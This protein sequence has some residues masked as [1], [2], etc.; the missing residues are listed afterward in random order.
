MTTPSARQFVHRLALRRRVQ[1]PDGSYQENDYATDVP[2]T[3]APLPPQTSTDSDA[4]VDVGGFTCT[5]HAA[6]LRESNKARIGDRATLV[7]VDGSTH[8]LE[9]K[10]TGFRLDNRRTYLD[11][12]L[13][14]VEE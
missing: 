9:V 11:L 8:Q 13:H 14:F 10:R 1:Q 6:G 4:P 12:R 3:A 5:V 7:L 2:A